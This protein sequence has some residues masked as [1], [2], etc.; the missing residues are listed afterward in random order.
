MRFLIKKLFFIQV[1]ISANNIVNLLSDCGWVLR[2][3]FFLVWIWV[4]LRTFPPFEALIYYS[5]GAHP[6]RLDQSPVYMSRA[7]TDKLW[8]ANL[9]LVFILTHSR[10][11]RWCNKLLWRTRMTL[12]KWYIWG[13][14][15]TY[16]DHRG[17]NS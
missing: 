2:L 8:C 10:I 13:E 9:D 7:A 14:H 6:S 15:S 12:S 5:T 1:W 17:S 11:I 4:S 3:C 16:L